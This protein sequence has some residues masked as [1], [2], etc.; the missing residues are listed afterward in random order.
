M[1]FRKVFKYYISRNSVQ[2]KSSCSMRTDIQDEGNSRFSQF[3]E[4]TFKS[5]ELSNNISPTIEPAPCQN[6][7]FM[8]PSNIPP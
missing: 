5:W 6:R 8:V 1:D 4:H 3:Y 2:Y 7:W